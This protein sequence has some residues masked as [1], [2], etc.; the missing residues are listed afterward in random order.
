MISAVLF[1]LC[2]LIPTL[3]L[4]PFALWAVWEGVLLG[5]VYVIGD[6]L[7]ASM[8]VHGMH[9]VIGFAIFRWERRRPVHDTGSSDSKK[10]RT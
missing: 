4:W 7:A 6:S 2:H 9:D 8:L 5:G 1:G 3:Q 10:Y